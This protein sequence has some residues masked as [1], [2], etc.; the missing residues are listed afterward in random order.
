M[1]RQTNRVAADNRKAR[2]N[3]SIES[4]LEAGIQLTGSEVKSLRAGRAN[5]AEAYARPVERE[6][7]LVNAHIGEYEQAGPA[8][9]EARR[10]RKLLLQRRQIDRLLG[11]VQREGATM[12]PL[13]L[14]FNDRGIAKLELGLARGKR[15]YDKRQ[16]EKKRDWQ[17]EQARLLRG[18]E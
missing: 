3:Y 1:A 14:Y 18:K 13:R 5:I 8:G 6:I 15:Q 7:F 9:H 4:S 17:R 10:P 11:A 12:V 16:T 2:R